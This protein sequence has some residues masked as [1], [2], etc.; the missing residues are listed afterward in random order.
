MIR[1][2]L[3]N[4]TGDAIDFFEAMDD[5]QAALLLSFKLS[6]LQWLLSMGDTITIV[7]VELKRYLVFVGDCYYPQGGMQDFCGSRETE[8]AA[9][10]FAQS[11]INGEGLRWA[12]VYDT[13]ANKIIWRQD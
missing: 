4:S 13:A 8:E 2:S 6:S 9:I 5:A 12:H 1:V 11:K 3:C 10:T 7:D